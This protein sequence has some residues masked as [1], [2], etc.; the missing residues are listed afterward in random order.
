MDNKEINNRLNRIEGQIVGLSK[1][2]QVGEKDA[3]SVVQQIMALK[4]ALEK[5]GVLILMEE[6]KNGGEDSSKQ[7]KIFDYLI[8]LS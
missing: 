2:I 5:V 4:S 7:E 8:K 1:M 3:L 6:I